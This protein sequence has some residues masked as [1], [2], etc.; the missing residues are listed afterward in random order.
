MKHTRVS[1]S[2]LDHVLEE[3]IFTDKNKELV[4]RQKGSGGKG[5]EEEEEDGAREGEGVQF[6]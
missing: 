2:T 6:A 4:V 5:G 1:G 3:M